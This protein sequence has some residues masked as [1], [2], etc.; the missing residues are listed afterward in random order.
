MFQKLYRLGLK[1]ALFGL[2]VFVVLLILLAVYVIK[3]TKDLPDYRELADYRPPVMSRV[4]AGNGALI[5][6]FAE[7]HRIYVPIDSIPEGVISAFISAEDK[8]FYDHNGISYPGILKAV[9]INLRNVFSGKRLVGGST[10]TQQVAK[11]FLLTSERNL[12]RKIRELF[13]ARRIE[14]AYTKDRI[15]E[16]YLNEIYMGR[17]AYGVAAAALNY[18]DKSLDQLTISEMA[19]LAALPKGPYNYEPEHNMKKALARRN[20]VLS[21]M[22]E[23]HYIS[24]QQAQQAKADPL[25]A[26]RRL[27]GR[28]YRS[29]SYFVEEIRRLIIE[30]YGKQALYDG[31]LSIRSTLDTKLQIMAEKALQDGLLT[32][33]KRHGWRGAVDRIA[34][35]DSWSQ[36]LSQLDLKTGMENWRT[37]V[38]LGF[39]DYQ[40]E[41]G[42]SDG[43]KGIIPEKG[44]LWISSGAE[45]KGTRFKPE[46]ILSKGDVIFVTEKK[47]KPDLKTYSTFA[48]EQIPKANGALIA[49]DPH[50]GRILAMIGGY[51]FS[52]SQFNRATQAKR[53]P[54]SAFKPFV[55]ASALDHGYTPVSKILDVPF[56]KESGGKV[57]IPKNYSYQYSGLSTLRTGLEKSR[58]IMTVRLANDIGLEPISQYGERFGLYDSLIPVPSIALGAVETSLLKLVTAYGVLLNNGKMIEP[59]MIDRIQDL[60]GKTIYIHDKRKCNMC[61]SIEWENELSP[62]V[63]EKTGEQIINPVTAFQTV[64]MLKGVVDRGTG[65]IVRSVNKTLAGKTGTSNDYKDAWFIGFSPDLVAGVYIGFDQ[66]ASLGNGEAGGRVAAPIFRDFMKSALKNKLDQ[67]FRVPSGV[68]FVPINIKTGELSVIGSKD[69]ILEAFHPG[70]EPKFGENQSVESKEQDL[71]ALLSS[72]SNDAIYDLFEPGTDQ[73]INQPGSLDNSSDPS[74]KNK[75]DLSDQE[76]EQKEEQELDGLY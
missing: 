53:Q 43:Q 1:L 11:N 70:T 69:T 3:I 62:P 36:T 6:E 10:I 61:H 22:E 56:V 35:N 55:Y 26:H 17:R 27:Q 5:A 52:L 42:F 68:R 50:T 14:K 18:F 12:D 51:S 72:D 49:L 75:P 33:D 63:L 9:L 44:Y 8:G 38:V 15:L 20:W 54:G 60:F 46:S 40:I 71:E 30:M 25:I 73:D 7:Q 24:D 29:A 67:P 57:Y 58:N 13:I 39:S 65:R 45:K 32:Y 34:L 47:F 4:H 41:I 2:G 37:A 76:E 23:N 66:P 59:T 48:L 28:K 21:E 74:N 31:G 64:W 19:F 16:L